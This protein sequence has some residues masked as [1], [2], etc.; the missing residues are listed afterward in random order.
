MDTFPTSPEAIT[1]LRVAQREVPT[2][3]ESMKL[4]ALCDP[5]TGKTAVGNQIPVSGIDSIVRNPTKI[6]LLADLRRGIYVEKVVAGILLGKS[7]QTGRCLG[8]RSSGVRAK[9]NDGHG[10]T[11]EMGAK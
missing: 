5:V 4:Q 8:A 2:H 9:V 3:G 7:G 1:Q 6:E 10:S 11:F